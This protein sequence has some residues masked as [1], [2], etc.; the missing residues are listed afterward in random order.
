ML[1][2]HILNTEP[3]RPGGRG[4]GV[5]EEGTWRSHLLLLFEVTETT[6]SFEYLENLMDVLSCHAFHF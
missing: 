3:F 1:G 5:C 2:T 4:D 6:T